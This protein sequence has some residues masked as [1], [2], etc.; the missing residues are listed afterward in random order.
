MVKVFLLPLLSSQ[1]LSFKAQLQWHTSKIIP[2]HHHSATIITL[3]LRVFIT[4]HWKLRARQES[5]QKS[6]TKHLAFT[7]EC[8]AAILSLSTRSEMSF[9]GSSHSREIWSTRQQGNS[10]A[11]KATWWAIKHK[12]IPWFR[13]LDSKPC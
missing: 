13:W 11:P 8:A 5:S 12:A 4:V 9:Q 2:A 1:I 3:T 6:L 10:I 7:V